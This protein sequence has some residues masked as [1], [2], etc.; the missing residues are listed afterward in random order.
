[1]VA[2]WGIATWRKANSGLP[3]NK[4]LNHHYLT[5]QIRHHHPRDE[6]KLN[7]IIRQQNLNFLV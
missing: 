3:T 6:N 5:K 7:L 4:V 1:M 2:L